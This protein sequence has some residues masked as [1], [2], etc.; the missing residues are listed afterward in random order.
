MI[1]PPRASPHLRQ[2]KQKATRTPR[3]PPTVAEELNAHNKW[4][5]TAEGEKRYLEK[6][7]S[8]KCIEERGLVITASEMAEYGDIER[9]INEKE[10]PH[11]MLRPR[12]K[13]VGECGPRVLC[14][15][16]DS[17][18][19][20]VYCKVVKVLFSLTD[21]NNVL[22]TKDIGFEADEFPSFINNVGDF[23]A[24]KDLLCIPDTQWEISGGLHHRLRKQETHKITRTWLYF[25]TA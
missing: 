16:P 1:R 18:P 3:R 11:T 19:G 22:S 7:Q 9:I 8:R 2:P 6:Y 10:W 17:G 24:V 20:W 23:N 12:H 15:C 13:S 5:L 21:I 25:V 4:F 14:K